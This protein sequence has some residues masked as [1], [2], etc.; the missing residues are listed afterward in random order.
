MGM[1]ILDLT[2]RFARLSDTKKGKN[3]TLNLEHLVEAVCTV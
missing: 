3:V 2:E 1:Q